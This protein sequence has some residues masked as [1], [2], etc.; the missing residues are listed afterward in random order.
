M[1]CRPAEPTAPAAVTPTA[2]AVT[3]AALATLATPAFLNAITIP[4]L[5]AK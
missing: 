2:H 1:L 4:T 5:T 3:P